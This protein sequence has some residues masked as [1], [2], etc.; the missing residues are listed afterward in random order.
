MK[1]LYSW[2]KFAELYCRATGRWVV[3]FSPWFDGESFDNGSSYG[4][5]LKAAPILADPAEPDAGQVITDGM[6]F[7]VCGDESQAIHEY[8]RIVGDDGPTAENPYNGPVHIYAC[9][10]GPSGCTNEN[11]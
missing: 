2:H 10:F 3:C 7:I 1:L 4:E 6:G 11:T 8:N 5:M 9:I